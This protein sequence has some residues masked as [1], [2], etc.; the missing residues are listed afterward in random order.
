MGNFNGI[1]IHVFRT[2]QKEYNVK[3]VLRMLH[4]AAC[5]PEEEVAWQHLRTGPLF[6]RKCLRKLGIRNLHILL[7]N[8]GT[9]NVSRLVAT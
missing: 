5:R 3:E 9:R 6:R 2:I 4:L 8:N 1:R 7:A